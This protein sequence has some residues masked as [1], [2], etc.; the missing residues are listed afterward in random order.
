MST[1]KDIYSQEIY[2]WY[3]IQYQQYGPTGEYPFEGKRLSADFATGDRLGWKWD[4]T[5]NRDIQEYFQPCFILGLTNL[6][7]KFNLES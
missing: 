2:T 5:R 1:K 7:A 4:R 3:V 6:A